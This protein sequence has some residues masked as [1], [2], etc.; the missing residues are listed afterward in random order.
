MESIY[1][2]KTKARGRILQ[3]LEMLVKIPFLY[4]RPK[5]NEFEKILSKVCKIECNWCKCVP[6]C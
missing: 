5:E 2:A 6:K 3:N 4:F 1:L